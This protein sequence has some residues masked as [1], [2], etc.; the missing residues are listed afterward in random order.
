MV[1]HRNHGAQMHP[2]PLQ[3][4]RADASAF[5]TAGLMSCAMEVASDSAEPALLSCDEAFALAAA[6][7]N[8]VSTDWALVRTVPLPPQALAAASAK[9]DA[10]AVAV[11]EASAEASAE[12]WQPAAGCREALPM[13]QIELGVLTPAMVCIAARQV[14]WVYRPRLHRSLAC[15]C[16]CPCLLV[17][18]MALNSTVAWVSRPPHCC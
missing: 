5:A 11:A 16:P 12:P 17:H 18:A 9:A 2:L 10:R 14:A 1:N 3:D 4:A 15:L 7:A 6:W 8:A 13:S